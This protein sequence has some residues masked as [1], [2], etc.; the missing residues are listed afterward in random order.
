MKNNS[1]KLKIFNFTLLLLVF[2]FTFYVPA[3]LAAVAK[4][5]FVTPARLVAPGAISEK[6]TAS[7]GEAVGE[8]S[9]LFLT[10]SSP[11]GEFSSNNSNWQTVTKL[12]WN[13]NWANRSFY[14][15]DSTSGAHTITVTLTTRATRNS[16]TANQT[17]T[18]GQAVV[19]PPPTPPVVELPLSPPPSVQPT[20]TVAINPRP[21]ASAA[22]SSFTVV[23]PS[24]PE[25]AAAPVAPASSST[26]SAPPLLPAGQVAD[27]RLAE[28][29]RLG[30]EL[31]LAAA[32]LQTAQKN[33]PPAAPKILE[34]DN[35]DNANLAAALAP[36]IE[37]SKPPS[38]FQRLAA[39]PRK[40]WQLVKN[41]FRRS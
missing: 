14:Y 11:T 31:A 6:L 2:S 1:S 39:I 41:L 38:F 7:S 36:S 25:A 10:S 27:A 21:V 5:E 26:P 34:I 17:I 33:R 3:V 16:W 30:N 15:R 20:S 4:L 40:I 23:T 9:D 28:L 37:I 12:T 13:N 29:T 24:R 32:K 19:E 8:T 22:T 35:V 18:V